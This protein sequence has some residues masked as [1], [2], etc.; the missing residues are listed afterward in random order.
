MINRSL[1][2]FFVMVITM[3]TIYYALEVNNVIIYF[4]RSK[5]K[6]N[7]HFYIENEIS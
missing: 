4:H 5:N 3:F 7:R 6:V 1:T 2:F